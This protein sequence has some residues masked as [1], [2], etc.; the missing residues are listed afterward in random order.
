VSDNPNI[1]SMSRE[2]LQAALDSPQTPFDIARINELLAEGVAS[3]SPSADALKAD[4]V[5]FAEAHGID[6]S[7]TKADIFERIAEAEGSSPEDFIV[8]DETVAEDQSEGD[9][10]QAES[11]HPAGEEAADMGEPI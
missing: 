1:E 9:A 8:E 2:E 4:L 5:A 11:G 7:G 6:S 10:S 3:E